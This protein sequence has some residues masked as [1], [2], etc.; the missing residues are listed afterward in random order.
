MNPHVRTIRERIAAVTHVDELSEHDV[1][2]THGPLLWRAER[3]RGHPTF[4]PVYRTGNLYSYSP[5]ALILAKG[6]LCFDAELARQCSGGSFRYLS[7]RGVLDR[8]IERI[9]GPIQSANEIR[10]G[11]VYVER[12]VAALLSDVAAAERANPGRTNIILCGGKDSLNLLLLPWKNPTYAASAP[13]NFELVRQFVI[14]NELGFDVVRLDDLADDD[15]LDAEVLENGCRNNL[16]HCR[17]GVDLYRLAR[18]HDCKLVFWKGQLGDLMMTPH[19]KETAHPP[20]A[21]SRRSR[22]AYTQFEWMLPKAIRQWISSGYLEPRFRQILWERSAMWQGA[23]LSLVRSIADC[24]V[25]SA[26]HGPAMAEVLAEVN[27][28]ASVQ[29]DVRDEVGAHLLGRTVQYPLR[30][31]GPSPSRLRENRSTPEQFLAMLEAIGVAVE[32]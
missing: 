28:T 15:I 2:S 5:L 10:S 17:W 26:Y 30:N 24:L 11:D 16:T 21:L 1:W 31:P 12:I 7:G 20:H 6:R 9:G 32:R 29:D 13:P 19:W 25:L 3:F 23:H 18:K 4:Y 14:D 22:R 8:E 27:L